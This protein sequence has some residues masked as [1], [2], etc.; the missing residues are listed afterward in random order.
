[1]SLEFGGGSVDFA[2]IFNTGEVTTLATGL[3]GDLCS[4]GLV[5]NDVAT[6]T[7]SH[8]ARGGGDRTGVL[9]EIAEKNDVAARAGDGA[10]VYDA[11]TG[12]AAVAI[13]PA[14][15]EIPIGDIEG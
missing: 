3:D 6:G 4:A 15:K 2:G 12:R 14:V 8:R 1:M 10:I 5:D 9:Q 7:K 13:T 11:L